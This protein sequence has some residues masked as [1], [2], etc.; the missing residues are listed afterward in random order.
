VVPEHKSRE[1]SLLF[2][3]GTEKRKMNPLSD[4]QLGD[5]L[6]ITYE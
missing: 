5:D 4:N 1:A 3:N 2:D 6:P